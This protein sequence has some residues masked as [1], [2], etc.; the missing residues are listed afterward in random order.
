MIRE[1]EIR[2]V[3]IGARWIV[4]ISELERLAPPSC[5]ADCACLCHRAA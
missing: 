5:A 3:R 1:G 2:A 4:P